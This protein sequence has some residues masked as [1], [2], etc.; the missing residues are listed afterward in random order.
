M[1]LAAALLLAAVPSAAAAQSEPVAASPDTALR[2]RADAVV[3]ILAGGGDYDETFSPAFRQAVPRSQFDAVAR[4]LTQALGAPQRIERVEPHGGGS[5]TMTIGYARGSATAE[6]VVDAAAPHVVTGLRITGTAVRNDSLSAIESELR[7]LPGQVALGVYALGSGAPRPLLAIRDDAPAPLASSFKLWV[8]AELARQVTAGRHRW[9]EVVPLGQPSLP[10]GVLQDWPA[11]A[12]VTVQT[13]ATQ[14]VS[15]S[16]NSATDTLVALLGRRALDAGAAAAGL[17]PP[18]L[19]TREAFAIKA[20]PAL[21]RAWA[22]ADAA[23][24]RAILT[25]EAPRI[26]AARLDGTIFS[27]GPLATD[28]VEWFAAPRDTARL[29]DGFRRAG[30]VPLS[31]LAVNHGADP[32]TVGRFAYLGYKGGSEPGVLTLNFLARTKDGRWFALAGAWHRPDGATD[33]PR[34]LSLLTRAL[35]LV[36]TP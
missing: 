24:R 19:T 10:S 31:I 15:I 25:R 14:M 3:T 1:R 27:H 33:E 36:A 11:H 12:P 28:S 22:A 23:G 8:L 20:D 9:A 30:G 4:N 17:A 32:L 29:L 6:I 26:A 21:T 18:V 5:A 34:L 7:A 2:S 35:A 16:D 13:L